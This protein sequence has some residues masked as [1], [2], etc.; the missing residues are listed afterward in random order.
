MYTHLCKEKFLKWNMITFWK[1]KQIEYNFVF[2]MCILAILLGLNHIFK[3]CLCLCWLKKEK[4][5]LAL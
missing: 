5:V 4:R 3:C 1:R 2:Q